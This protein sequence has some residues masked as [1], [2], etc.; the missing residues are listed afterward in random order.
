MRP[1]DLQEFLSERPFKPMRLTLT[2]GR[3]YEIHHP[4]MLMIGRTAVV[5][6]VPRAGELRPV[7]DRAITVSHSHIM[8]IEPL[9]TPTAP[10]NN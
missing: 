2:D 8:Q 3:T 7:Y 1:D 4:E 6:G 5:I 9:Q 10:A